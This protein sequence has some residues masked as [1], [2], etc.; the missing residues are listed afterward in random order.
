MAKESSYNYE[1]AG[2]DKFLDRSIDS[3]GVSNLDNQP[4]PVRQMNYEQAQVSGSLG[5]RLQ[6]GSI[7]IDGVG[8]RIS[9]FDDNGR[10]AVTIG[11]LGD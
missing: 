8:R 10:E 9:I 3:A 6:I 5:D 4:N 7:V 2:F 11:D 1:D